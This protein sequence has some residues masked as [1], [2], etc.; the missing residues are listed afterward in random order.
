LCIPT[1]QISTIST[2]KRLP[3]E[4]AEAVFPLRHKAKGTMVAP[5]QLLSTQLDEKEITVSMGT[6]LS[7]QVP[8]PRAGMVAPVLSLR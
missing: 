4:S 8:K 2:K 5:E 1:G 6:H 3:A 7:C